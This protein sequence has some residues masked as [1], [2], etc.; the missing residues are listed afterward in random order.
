MRL[1]SL[2][3][4]T[5]SAP[6]YCIP[7]P[8]PC[9]PPRPYPPSYAAPSTRH[10][11]LHYTCQPW[12]WI[13]IVSQGSIGTLVVARQQQLGQGRCRESIPAQLH[14]TSVVRTSITAMVD[15]GSSQS[16]DSQV[17]GHLVLLGHTCLEGNHLSHLIIPYTRQ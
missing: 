17:L 15:A 8:P 13:L 11:M 1:T 9:P 10:P 3:C 12:Q 7:S 2:H 4:P 16:R 6:Q 5:V 14:S